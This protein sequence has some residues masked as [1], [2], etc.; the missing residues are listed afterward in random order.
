MKRLLMIAVLAVAGYAAEAQHRFHNDSPCDIEYREV[1]IDVTGAPSTCSITGVG[2]WIPVPPTTHVMMPNP[3][4][5][6]PPDEIA[7]E[8]RYA[9][10]TGCSGS[11]ILK[12]DPGPYSTTPCNSYPSHDILPPCSCNSGNGLHLH[13]NSENLHVDP[14]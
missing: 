1:C 2:S 7:I 5:C 8:V 3:N 13:V 6:T 9:P 11:V 14:M 10:S 12:F 4:M